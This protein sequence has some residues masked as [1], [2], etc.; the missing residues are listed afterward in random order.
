MRPG[1]VMIFSAGFGTRM[2]PLTHTRPKPLIEVA[3]RTLIDRALDLADDA[4]ISRK[5]INTHYLGAQLA[6]HLAGRSDVCLSPEVGKP[7]ET[8]GGLKR[9]LP[10]LDG[11]CVFT[12][13]PD[14]VWTG[15]NPLIALA[16]AWEPRRMDALLMLV[17]LARATGH[18]GAGDFQ[19]AP[20]GRVSRLDRAAK[21]PRVYTGAQIIKTDRVAKHADTRFSLHRIWEEMDAEGRVFGIIH[22]GGWADV[23]TPGGIATAE[24]LLRENGDV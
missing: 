17:P 8:G 23:G 3:G 19:C 16:S 18:E 6:D 1:A 20:D 13:N 12:L 5:V 7:L 11:D 4:G 15:P 2:R 24:T 10:F 21:E 9:A 14:A 22:P